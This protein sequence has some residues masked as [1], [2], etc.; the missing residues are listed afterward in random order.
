MQWRE[1][2]R[3]PLA[4]LTDWAKV[5]SHI[6]LLDLRQGGVWLFMFA[7]HKIFSGQFRGRMM[8]VLHGKSLRESGGDGI[9]SLLASREGRYDLLSA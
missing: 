6:T 4:C 2:Q 8:D 1:I 5:I 3:N 9:D 7:P